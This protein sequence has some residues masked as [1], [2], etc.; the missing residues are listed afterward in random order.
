MQTDRNAEY[1]VAGHP[2]YQNN[3]ADAEKYSAFIDDELL[4][5]AKKKVGVRKFNTIT[6]AGC[7][8]GGLSAFDIA[9]NHADKIDKVGVFSGSFWLRDKDANDPT[10]SD[11]FDR[12]EYTAIKSSRKRPKLQY[13]F[14]AGTGEETGDRD[15]D[16]VIDVVD[17]TKDM[18]RL[19]GTKNVAPG[20]I[21]YKETLG[22]KHDYA[23]W[24]NVFGEFLIWAV[25]K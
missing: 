1:G 22:G 9:W 3:G 5:F 20:D 18:I 15:K 10:Y 8:L 17:D 6:I 4:A 21:V 14:Y 24:S 16:G 7:S 23:D 12:L 2:D 19:L 13:W 25:G 11:E